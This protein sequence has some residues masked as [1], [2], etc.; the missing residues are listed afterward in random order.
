M[1]YL[2][3]AML[4]SLISFTAN[5]EERLF[6]KMEWSKILEQADKS[7][8]CRDELDCGYLQLYNCDLGC[9]TVPINK[10]TK[11]MMEI[12]AGTYNETCAGVCRAPC[13]RPVQPKCI[14]NKCSYDLRDWKYLG[15]QPK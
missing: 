15:L 14:K 10:N 5:A 12:G 1:R 7:N 3:I 6:C 4:V 2:V 8:K 9:V 13:A 11:T